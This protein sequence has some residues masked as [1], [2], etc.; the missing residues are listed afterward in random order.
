[1]N[2]KVQELLRR[3]VKIIDA[4]QV[5]VAPE[6]EVSRI[7][8]GSVLYPG[9]RLLGVKTLV[10]TG[11]KIGLEGPAVLTDTVVASN[12]V[13]ASGYLEGAVLLPE[14]KAG[15]DSHFRSGTLLEERAS[16]AHSVGLKQTILLGNATLGSLINFCDVLLYG[17]SSRMNHSEVGS[18]FVH[19]NFTP[20]RDK[21]TPT[22]A[23][24]V[25]HGVFMD[26]PSIFLG[27]MSGM[28]GPLKLGF[29]A[30]TVAGQVVRHDVTDKTMYAD[31]PIQMK[32]PFNSDEARP[33]EKHIAR[34]RMRN[35]EYIEQLMMLK[36]WYKKVRVA[37][38]VAVQ[39]AEMVLVYRG[40]LDLL[41][42][43]IGERFK[44]YNDFA[45]KYNLA[46]LSE[47]DFE[48]KAEDVVLNWRAELDYQDWV[49]QLGAGERGEILKRILGAVGFVGE[50]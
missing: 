46:E 33:S 24:D 17:G 40:A 16:T 2:S 27:G 49:R 1:M 22:L 48:N 7:F 43:C 41:D 29:G 44:R 32:K 11:A 6:V 14:A 45:R 39:D 23:G 28:V 10:G 3:G 20:W 9:V 25:L 50:K 19:F 34:K 36:A 12:A 30:V 38:S 18:G 13:V 26:Q 4:G 47:N 8:P 15:A 31:L 35:I 37:R 42:N 5:F 21:A